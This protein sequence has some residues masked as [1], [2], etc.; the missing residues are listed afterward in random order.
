M[1]GTPDDK[2]RALRRVQAAAEAAVSSAAPDVVVLG[3]SPEGLTAIIHGRTGRFVVLSSEGPALKASAYTPMDHA[4][5]R[6]PGP[7]PIRFE[8][9]LIHIGPDDVKPL[10]I[11][12]LAS[13][14][15]RYLGS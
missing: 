6:A 3:H 13:V 1:T 10:T 4:P 15:L 2:A 12:T 7:D 14:I 11:P 8:G 5:Y 9:H